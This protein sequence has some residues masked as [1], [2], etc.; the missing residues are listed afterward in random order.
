ME[1]EFGIGWYIKKVKL[2][3]YQN[4]KIF[5]CNQTK[6][7]K[8]PAQAKAQK[9]SNWCKFRSMEITC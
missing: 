3:M 2:Q 8:N 4:W 7:K 5:R 1:T 6:D 9:K